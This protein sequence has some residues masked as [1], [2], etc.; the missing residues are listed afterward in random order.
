MM[1]HAVLYS[2]PNPQGV[3]IIG[4]GNFGVARE[5]LKHKC[6]Q[7]IDLCDIDEKAIIA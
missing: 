5:V 7:A 4:W 2:N 1:S 3:L 6:E